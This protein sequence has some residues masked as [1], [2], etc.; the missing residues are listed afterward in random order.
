MYLCKHAIGTIE[1]YTKKAI[2]LGYKYLG[3]S[4]H[5]PISDELTTLLHS[6]RM[7]EDEYENIYLKELEKIKQKHKDKIILYKS[8]EIEFYPHFMDK[9]L[10]MKNELD[11]IVLGQHEIFHKG[12]YKNVYNPTFK[13][14]D[15]QIY[16]ETVIQALK[17]GLFKILAHPD[18][19]L[20]HIKKYSD[21]CKS[22]TQEILQCALETDTVIEINANGIRNVKMK[23]QDYLDESLYAYPR[24]EFW[25]QVK[26]FQY[27]NP[28]L[29][30]IIS[31]DAHS[32]EYLSDDCTQVAYAFAKKHDIT[33]IEE[34]EKPFYKNPNE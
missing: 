25:E 18:I 9:Y 13:E 31:D 6:R 16:K 30:V 12:I 24:P 27:K 34:I 22:I 1:D 32:Y 28:G 17:T 15:A 29:K 11:Y 5:G 14:D 23:N 8:V 26:E 2:S 10:K 20:I 7:S 4:D 19:Y 33:I 21:I 3:M